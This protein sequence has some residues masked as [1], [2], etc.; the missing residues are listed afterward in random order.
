MNKVITANTLKTGE[1][2]FWGINDNGGRGWICSLD[3]AERFDESADLDNTV[4]DVDQPDHVV[5][6]YTILV[7]EEGG[8][9]TPYHIR[10]KIRA[11]G[12][13]NYDHRRNGDVS[14]MTTK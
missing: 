6:V 10:E 8:L 2:V 4:A 13:G 9:I 12:P 3:N 5:G 11:L 7:T 14:A 1:V